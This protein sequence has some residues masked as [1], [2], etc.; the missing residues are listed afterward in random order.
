M[1]SRIIILAVFLSLFLFL[2][3]YYL[4]NY[5]YFL[6]NNIDQINSSSLYTNTSLNPFKFSV[7]KSMLGFIILL[8]VFILLLMFDINKKIKFYFIPI[9]LLL[10]IGFNFGFA[11]PS[12]KNWLLKSHKILEQNENV[13]KIKVKITHIAHS[14]YWWTYD[15]YWNYLSIKPVKVENEIPLAEIAI[16]DRLRFRA[17]EFK[18]GDELTIVQSK[19]YPKIFRIEFKGY[20]IVP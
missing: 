1:K 17:K 3:Y 19:K 2:P 13:N 9:I 15:L 14:K 4:N 20:D 7:V 11:S 18:V 10:L 8:L 12:Y 5:T 6:V 16:Y